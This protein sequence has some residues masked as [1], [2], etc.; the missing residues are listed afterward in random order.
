MKSLSKPSF[1]WSVVA[2][3]CGLSASSIGVCINCAGVFYTPVSDALGFLRGSFALNATLA[4]AAVSLSALFVRRLM[5]RFSYKRILLFGMVLA[6]G[7][8]ALMSLSRNIWLFY[9]LGFLRGLGAG[10]F[11]SV[12]VTI[13]LTS[14]FQKR[15]GLATSVTLSFSGLAGAVCSPLFTKCIE[16]LGWQAAYLLTAGVMAALVL[17]ALLAPWAVTPQ[18]MG[19]LPYG[20]R[21]GAQK[22]AFVPQGKFRYGTVSFLALCLMALLHTSIAGIAQHMPGF[23][24]SIA[25]TAET[26]A[27]MM[28]LS[29]VGNIATKL[30]IGLL[31]DRTGPVKA[32]V[33]MIFLNAGA[34][35]LCIVGGRQANAP[36]LYLSSFLYGSVYSVG[37]VGFSLLSRRFFGVENYPKAYS[38][39]GI[40]TTMGSAF[41]QPLIGYLYDFTGSYLPMFWIALS[42]HAVDLAL[43]ALVCRR[44]RKEYRTKTFSK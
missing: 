26:G 11:S 7:A 24:E 5:D 17:P 16:V 42:F 21:Q 34:L 10:C 43:L 40:L 35:G 1:H 38:V 29:M 22:G 9:L 20:G 37:A 12:P 2:M 4:Q 13:V 23:A 36:L 19:L 33:V 15:H 39:L 28:S 30:L 25:L 41:S 18:R 31:S 3:L 14:W 32:S 44:S 27:L 6:A 8:T